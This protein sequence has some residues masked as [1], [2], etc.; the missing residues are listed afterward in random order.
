MSRKT[1][2]DQRLSASLADDFEEALE[3][4][5]RQG[6]FLMLV[7]SDGI[8][9]GVERVTHWLNEQGSSSPFKFGLVELKFYSLGDQRL[10]IPRTVLK[11]HEVSRNVVVV[12]IQAGANVGVAARVTMNFKAPRVGRYMNPVRSRPLVFR[13]PRARSYSFCARKIGNPPPG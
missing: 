11:T 12:D 10:V 3:R 7:V 2:E 8:R 6:E 4:H 5:L 9:A 13:S 1:S